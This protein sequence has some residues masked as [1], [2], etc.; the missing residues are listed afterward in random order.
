MNK[1]RDNIIGEGLLTASERESFIGMKRARDFERT[2]GDA[3]D[4]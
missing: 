4:R 3:S 1:S 2:A